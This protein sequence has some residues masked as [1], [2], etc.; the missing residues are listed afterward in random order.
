MCEAAPFSPFL[1]IE[2]DINGDVAVVKV[3]DVIGGR[4]QDFVTAKLKREGVVMTVLPLA[5]IVDWLRM[6]PEW[7]HPDRDEG[8]REHFPFLL[9][10]VEGCVAVITKK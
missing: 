5:G 4:R 3:Y 9:S 8:K 2:G 6:E 7:N 1:L 10:R